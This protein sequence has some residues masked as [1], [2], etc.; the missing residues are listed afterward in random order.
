MQTTIIAAR[1]SVAYI[2]R[3]RDKR[4]FLSQ[5]DYMIQHHQENEWK[6]ERVL[7]AVA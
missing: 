5:Y 4:M 7:S 6:Q 2:G 1:H 3:L